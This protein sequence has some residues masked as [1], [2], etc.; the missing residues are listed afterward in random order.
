MK[1]IHVS[2]SDSIGGA[3]I[4]ANQ[5][6]NNLKKKNILSKMLVLD[7]NLNDDLILGP[8][9]KLE[10]LINNLRIRF[11]RFL[12]RN[13]FKT[14]DK[15][16]FSFNLINTNV[17]KKLNNLDCDIVHLHWIG[18]EMISIS[19]IKKIQKPIVWSFHD[20]WP[21]NGGEHYS[22]NN[23]C[24]DGYNKKNKPK[25]DIGFDINRFLWNK[26]LKN[27]NINL[28]VICYSNWL[29][30][31]VNKSQIYKN[32]QITKIPYGIDTRFWKKT[33]K[34]LARKFY[35]LNSDCK[36]ILFGSTSG[37]NNRKGFNYLIEALNKLKIN[38]FKLLVAG[39]K[40]KN[41]D[42]LKCN[43]L[44]VGEVNGKEKRRKLI[45]A[46]D[47]TISPSILENFG[48][49]VLESNS[50]SVPCVV[51]DNTGTTDLVKHK[52]N[53]YIAR[54]KNIDDLKNGIEWC[55]EKKSRIDEL[56]KSARVMAEENHD[57][58]KVTDKVLNLYNSIMKKK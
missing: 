18:N 17:L 32:S 20:M 44:Y 8:N 11:S 56:S 46:S 49:F 37:T 2:Y 39:T 50:C 22:D 19:Q 16:S 38:N 48:L 12:K 54:N 5:L 13:F 34:H 55:L 52:I 9:T 33:D 1:I 35:K 26:K 14:S 28:N 3:G 58:T 51:F 57:E 6:H 53:G 24:I 30:E 15:E 7:K 40:P 27:L 42:K 10:I 31:L 45:S 36:I 29:K 25:L 47:L 4:A 21:I 23:R 41:L 43:Y